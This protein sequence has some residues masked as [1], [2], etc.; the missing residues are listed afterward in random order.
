MSVPPRFNV[1]GTGIS[2]LT[3]DAVVLVAFTAMKL[4]IDPIIVLYAISGIAA[5]FALERLYLSRWLAP[6]SAHAL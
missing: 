1:L 2:A 5:V 3:L 6:Q 4:Q